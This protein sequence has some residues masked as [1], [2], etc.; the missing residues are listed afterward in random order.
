MTTNKNTNKKKTNTIWWGALLSTALMTG[1][2]WFGLTQWQDAHQTAAAV[3]Q[4]VPPQNKLGPA[5]DLR[6]D[7]A[8]L[9]D[10]ASTRQHNVDVRA[11]Q[12]RH[13]AYL[14]SLSTAPGTPIGTFS[15]SLA[16]HN[17][18]GRVHNIMLACQKFNGKVLLPGE[19]LSFN[20]TTGDSNRPE[21][22]WQ[23]ATVIVGKQFEQGYGGGIC[24]VSSTMYNA[25]LRG[26]LTVTERYTHSLPVGYVEP[27]HDATVSYPELDFKFVN[28]MQT[29]VR[30]QTV[31]QGE[32]VTATILA[33]PPE[34]L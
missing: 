28:S 22:G 17:A 31:V 29:P 6:P 11:A 4:P 3:T 9:P 32:N 30:L 34:T 2:A 8:G 1:A 25:V 13:D 23:L 14:K 24:Q 12:E 18:S 7:M 20:Q 19:E 10:D 26:G 27:G 15:T 33:L 5:G 16:G 21:D